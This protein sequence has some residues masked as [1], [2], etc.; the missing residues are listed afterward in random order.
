MNLGFFGILDVAIV[1][2]VVLFAI[3]GWKKGFLVPVVKMVS[4]VF[5]LIASIILARPFSTVIDKWFGVSINE[6]IHEYLTSRDVFSAALSEANVRTAFES[7]S[8]PKFMIDWIVD[9]IDFDQIGM[10]I[11]DTIQP[12]IKSLVLVLISFLV[13]FFGSMIVF[14]ILKLLAKLLTSIPFIKQVDKVLGVIFGLVK[15]AAI[16]YI[17]MFMLAL[18][19]TIPAVNNV[20]GDFLAV[21]M[22]LNTDKFRLSKWVYNNNIISQIFYMFV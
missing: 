18:L 3:L 1:G 10:S 4:G 15:I 17:A 20:I 8:L 19:I 5:G 2:L 22:Q 12:W 16:I 7:M 11:I 14:F 6:H 21:D 9:S 13:L